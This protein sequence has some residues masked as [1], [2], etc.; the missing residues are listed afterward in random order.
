MRL[1]VIASFLVSRSSNTQ[2]TGRKRLGVWPTGTL[3][4]F[5]RFSRTC[6]PRCADARRDGSL[7]QPGAPAP[8]ARQVCP[9]AGERLGGLLGGTPREKDEEIRVRMGN[10]RFQLQRQRG[11]ANGDVSKVCVEIAGFILA[12]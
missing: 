10:S 3:L 12:P 4:R 1:S 7:C 2:R 8:R 11:R 5:S 6:G 9:C